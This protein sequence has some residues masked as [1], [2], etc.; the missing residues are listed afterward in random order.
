MATKIPNNA[1]RQDKNSL[2]DRTPRRIVAD[3][4]VQQA[5]TQLADTLDAVLKYLNN[6]LG[7][8]K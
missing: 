1:T 7:A 5:L 4:E 2:P 3:K 8:S 6:V